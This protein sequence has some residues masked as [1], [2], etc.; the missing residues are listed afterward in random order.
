[1][2]AMI[3]VDGPD[4]EVE[5]APGKFPDPGVF[6]EATVV[7]DEPTQH[8]GVLAADR[9]TQIVKL[10]G[11]PIAPGEL[12]GSGATYAAHDLDGDGIDEI[13]ASWGSDRRGYVVSNVSVYRVKKDKLVRAGDPVPVSYDD[14]AAEPDKM[15]SCEGNHA[16]EPAAKGKQ[17]AITVTT[18]SGKPEASNCLAK[19]KHVFALVGDKLVE[20]K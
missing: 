6:V 14:S 9:K 5:C 17:I 18:I 3:G 7:S 12:D 11:E 1:M 4:V 13:V 10:V 20:Q 16:V 19:G 2:A 15:T 8:M